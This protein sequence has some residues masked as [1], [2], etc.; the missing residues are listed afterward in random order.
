MQTPTPCNRLRARRLRKRRAD[1]AESDV[2]EADLSIR[3]VLLHVRGNARRG[4]AGAASNTGLG[5]GL[6]R[7][8]AA[9]EPEHI[10]IVVVPEG[11]DEH[12]ARGTGAAH[13]GHTT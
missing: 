5:R 13:R 4:R 1:G 9:V 3:A 11:H 8:V 6:V 2:R 10:G 12:H 7:R